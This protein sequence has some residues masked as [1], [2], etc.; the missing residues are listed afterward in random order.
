MMNPEI[1]ELW[2][3]ALESDRFNQT[4]NFLKDDNGYC[5]LGVLCTVL[6]KNRPL[7]P[8]KIEESDEHI[9]IYYDEE[10]EVFDH[11]SEGYA[12]MM[13]EREADS[14]LPGPVLE[15]LGLAGS[16]QKVLI[17]MNDGKGFHKDEPKNFHE[18]SSYIRKNA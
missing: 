17:D 10:E 4:T 16:I 15:Y 2:C 6:L 5:C 3:E 8:F 11:G 13:V 9:S 14:E 12:M 1:K 18:I 7:L